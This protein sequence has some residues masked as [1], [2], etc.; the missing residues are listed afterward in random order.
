MT[1]DKVFTDC[2]NELID[3]AS[4]R[5]VRVDFWALERAEEYLHNE[6]AL[7]DASLMARY[8]SHKQL[9]FTAAA[10][11]LPAIQEAANKNFEDNSRLLSAPVR[12]HDIRF[13]DVSDVDV[14]LGD[15]D[16]RP[17]ENVKIS[18]NLRGS[19]AVSRL[20]PSASGNIEIPGGRQPFKMGAIL[21]ATFDG[22]KYTKVKLG[23][24]GYTWPQAPEASV[25]P[26]PV[27]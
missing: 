20:A 14:A 26:P 8:E 16:P 22:T 6:L 18:A 19:V 7:L 11:A 21:P 17:G 5:S 12:L 24:Y 2:A 27:E 9:A 3:F 1:G 4:K 10:A 13:D 15:P 25:P 23:N